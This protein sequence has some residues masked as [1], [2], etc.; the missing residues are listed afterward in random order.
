MARFAYILPVR[1]NLKSAVFAARN[2]TAICAA[3]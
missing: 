2:F 1:R 3:P